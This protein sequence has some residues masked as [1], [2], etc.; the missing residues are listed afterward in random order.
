MASI[1]ET[2]EDSVVAELK[3]SVTGIDDKV[4]PSASIDEDIHRI[5]QQPPVIFVQCTGSTPDEKQPKGC[6]TQRRRVFTITVL[7]VGE[8]LRVTDEARATVGIHDLKSQARECL[9]GF[10]PEGSNGAME[11]GD[12][13][14]RGAF[15]D[16]NLLVWSQ[17]WTCPGIVNALT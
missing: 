7:F 9:Q 5:S 8:N 17:D 15:E 3:S 1:E 16:S 12:E 4:Y 11:E 10:R 6:P 14:E 2:L 13:E